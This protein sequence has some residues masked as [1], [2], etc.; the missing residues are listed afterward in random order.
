MDWSKAYD[1]V[2]REKLW[3][4]LRELG[5]GERSVGIIQNLYKDTKRRITL[6]S[7]MSDWLTSDAGVRQGCSLSPILFALY[8]ADLDRHL[9]KVDA[10]TYVQGCR[11][12]ALVYADDVVLLAERDRD[13]ASLLNAFQQFTEMKGLKLNFTKSKILKIGGSQAADGAWTLKNT[14]GEL[15]GIIEDATSTTYLGLE[16]SRSGGWKLTE[17]SKLAKLRRRAGMIK[18]K[19]S[20]L[21]QKIEPTKVMWE[22]AAKPQWEYGLE[23][24]NISATWIGKVE[25]VQNKMA[26]WLIEASYGASATGALG[27]LGWPKMA[28][29]I[30]LKKILLWGKAKHM[31]DTRLMK[32]FVLM[33]KDARYRSRW[34]ENV[35][36]ITAEY[37]IQE[38]M[39]NQKNWAKC[40]RK[41]MISEEWQK[42]GDQAR[43]REP[44]AFYNKVNRHGAE[45]YLR[46]EKWSKAFC[47]ARI[48]DQFKLA[49]IRQSETLSRCP[50]CTKEVSNMILHII[51]LCKAVTARRTWQ[52]GSTAPPWIKCRR[53]LNNGKIQH[54]QAVGELIMEWRARWMK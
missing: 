10:G 39:F 31:A 27:E 9:Q 23:C 49:G 54:I 53:A 7:G 22:L 13:M 35:K 12:Q 26:K 42:W 43:N 20:C 14:A 25:I 24:T 1:T 21:P 44:L 45:P 17:Q 18:A 29:A 38:E 46:E 15:E 19:A 33:M 36:Q 8:I 5:L 16:I 34:L 50:V 3:T 40:I 4:T 11:I 51:Q 48:G 32:R 37:G 28:F 2:W 47:Q 52:I 30:K 41:K 6:P